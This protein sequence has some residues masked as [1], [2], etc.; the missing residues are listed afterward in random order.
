M[1]MPAPCRVAMG[2][3]PSA[4]SSGSFSTPASKHAPTCARSMRIHARTQPF[5]PHLP[6]CR[7]FAQ[8]GGAHHAN[9]VHGHDE[10]TSLHAGTFLMDMLETLMTASLHLWEDLT[11]P[12]RCRV[13]A[14]PPRARRR[15]GSRQDSRGC[16]KFST[17][18]QGS[19]GSKKFRHPTGQPSFHESG[20]SGSTRPPRRLGLVQISSIV[21]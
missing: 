1:M 15:P 11:G 2:S 6:V 14:D 17:S 9:A 3:D 5:H 10:A 4:A 7:G 8:L 16:A 21:A 19:K 13:L 12:R 20:S 18:A